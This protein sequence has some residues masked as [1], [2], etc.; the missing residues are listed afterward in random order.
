MVAS[1]L[2]P[3]PLVRSTS[4]F[5][6]RFVSTVRRESHKFQNSHDVTLHETGSDVIYHIIPY[7]FI[8]FQPISEIIFVFESCENS[9]S[10]LHWQVLA[11]C[12]N[13]RAIDMW[14]WEKWKK[15]KIFGEN[16][17]ISYKNGCYSK[18]D[19]NVYSN[20][21]NIIRSRRD[22]GHSCAQ[23]M[24]F[25]R[26]LAQIFPILLRFKLGCFFFFFQNSPIYRHRIL[27]RVKSLCKLTFRPKQ[28]RP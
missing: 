11:I 17:S 6:C 23:K 21:I 16:R 7:N 24:I 25:F 20:V 2:Q 26:A 28:F 18:T 22:A 4:N 14:S 13:E 8:I 9:L 27:T 10:S 1:G 3:K 19:S 5:V 15:I 12:S